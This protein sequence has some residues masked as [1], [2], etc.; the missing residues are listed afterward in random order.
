M[1]V[2]LR[3][4]RPGVVVVERGRDHT[5]H[6]G[7]DDRATPSARPRP[8]RH[9]LAFHERQHI[10]H[11]VVMRPGDQRL[12]ARVGHAPQHAHRLRHGE[13]VVEPGD[14]P[15]GAASGLLTLDRG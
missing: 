6:V 2:Q 3:I 14:R 5:G 11:G 8:G 12:R 4:A 15:S 7:L 1:R 13:R 9:H 10:L